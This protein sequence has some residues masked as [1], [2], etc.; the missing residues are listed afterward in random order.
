M[1]RYLNT[2]YVHGG[3]GPDE[4]DCWGLVR[5]VRSEIFGLPELPSHADVPPPDKRRMTELCADIQEC[6]HLVECEPKEGAIATAWAGRLCVHV[7]ILVVA[8]SRPWILET[9]EPTGPTLTPIRTF[10]SRFSR[11][12]YYD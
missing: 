1:I 11:V 4:Y 8:D 9:D 10:E 6:A 5:A 12:V 7:G 2:R 3:R